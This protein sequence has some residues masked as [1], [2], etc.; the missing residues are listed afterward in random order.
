MLTSAKSKSC[1]S[2]HTR[3]FNVIRQKSWSI[4]PKVV[5]DTFLWFFFFFF[6]IPKLQLREFVDRGRSPRGG[7]FSWYS[8]DM[9]FNFSLKRRSCFRRCHYQLRSPR[10]VYIVRRASIIWHFTSNVWVGFFFPCNPSA[11]SL[12]KRGYQLCLNYKTNMLERPKQLGNG[13]HRIKYVIIGGDHQSL[14]LAHPRPLT[15]P[16]Y[17]SSHFVRVTQHGQ[18][19]FLIFSPV[20]RYGTRVFCLNLSLLGKQNI[21]FFLI[22]I[23]YGSGTRLSMLAERDIVKTSDLLP[24]F[25]FFHAMVT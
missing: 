1:L 8:V 22:T 25:F 19:W 24:F 10:P 13:C 11:W 14:L 21:F 17:V 12:M 2:A 16:Y 3:Q 9:C 20:Q 4:K 23:D 15:P 5:W 18:C 6:Y 7:L